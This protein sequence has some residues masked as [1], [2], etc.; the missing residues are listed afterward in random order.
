MQRRND[1]GRGQFGW[2]YRLGGAAVWAGV[3]VGR[4]EGGRG[5]GGRGLGA[6][7]VAVGARGA[8]AAIGGFGRTWPLLVVHIVTRSVH[9]GVPAGAAAAIRGCRADGGPGG[10]VSPGP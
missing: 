1:G 4:F 5:C 9:V 6:G 10:N 7:A 8:F 3:A 2:G